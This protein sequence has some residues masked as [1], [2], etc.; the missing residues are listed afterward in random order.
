MPVD[1]S[2][3]SNPAVRDLMLV[4]GRRLSDLALRMPGD[5]VTG[6]MELLDLAAKRVIA[7]RPNERCPEGGPFVPVNVIPQSYLSALTEE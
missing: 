3:L 5:E 6:Y 2:L 4:T 7:L 1:Y